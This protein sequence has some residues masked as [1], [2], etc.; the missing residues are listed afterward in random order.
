MNI[1][2]T[3][4]YK[5]GIFSNGLQQNIIFLSEL[6]IDIGF[7][8]IIV[9]DHSIDKCVDPPSNILIVEENEIGD[10][11]DNL[12]A[13]L[14][15]GWVLKKTTIDLIKD[16]N[17]STK[18]IYIHYG[19]RL[20]ADIE[21][22]SWNHTRCISDYRV[23]ENWVS[24]HYQFSI[25]YFKTYFKTQ[26]VFKL[27]YIWSP[28]YIDMH[29]KIWNKTG[30]TCYYSK[31]KEKNIGIFEPNLNITKHCLP[32]IMIAEELYSQD[33]GLFNKVNVYCT[34]KL[35]E[36]NYFKGLMWQLDLQ[37][38]GRVNFLN[39]TMVSKAL[40][41][42]VSVSLSNQLL[43]GLNYTYLE[44]LYFNLPLVHNSEYIKNAGYYYPE[45]D[46]QRGANALRGALVNHEYHLEDYKKQSQIIL[47][48]YSPKNPLV[49]E[50]YKKLLS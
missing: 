30:K 1:L 21:Q 14:Q 12:Y 43:N 11:C 47:N 45:Y 33:R 24:P 39:R 44:A 42:D 7:T 46:I 25:P 16:R 29:E 41:H 2:L 4:S 38:E 9:V 40:S 15:T 34:S 37:K 3:A 49:I 36:A 26:K 22:S 28:K 18:N 20:L 5:N 31:D 17:P 19:N 10:Y 35:R 50:K 23:D 8:P 13:V 32:S 6:L 27:P 48:Q